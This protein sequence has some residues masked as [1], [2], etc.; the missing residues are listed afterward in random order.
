[1]SKVG[2]GSRVEAND[3]ATDPD[4]EVVPVLALYGVRDRSVS[5]ERLVRRPSPETRFR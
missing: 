2:V 5:N 4:D 3:L 1:M